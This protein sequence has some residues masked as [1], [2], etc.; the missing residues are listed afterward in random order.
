M[1]PSVPPLPHS[2]PTG[3]LRAA[4]GW[5]RR[6]PEPPQRPQPGGPYNELVRYCRHL[7]RRLRRMAKD[8]ATENLKILHRF[9]AMGMAAVTL[10]VVS[11]IT[12]AAFRVA[13]SFGKLFDTAYGDVLCAKLALVALM[14]ALA[15]FNRFVVMPR[16]RALGEGASQAKALTEN[17]A[18]ELAVAVLVLGAAAV[19]GITPPPQ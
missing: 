13:G 2:G 14:L 18:A 10:I 1:R 7:A 17:V 19:L 6:R 16:L 8:P 11:G 3:A 5:F 9:S 4:L 15:Y 12:N